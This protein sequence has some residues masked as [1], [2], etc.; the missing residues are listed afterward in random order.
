MVD[1]G[2]Y[3]PPRQMLEV[4]AE[5]EGNSRQAAQEKTDPLS[6]CAGSKEEDSSPAPRTIRGVNAPISPSSCATPCITANEGSKEESH[7]CR[8][9]PGEDQDVSSCD[10]HA[11][12]REEEEEESHCDGRDPHGSEPEHGDHHDDHHDSSKE[13][14]Q[15]QDAHDR[16]RASPG[17]EV[18]HP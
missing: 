5:D 1:K 11:S 13:I 9:S 7:H 15:T 10:G 12:S 16:G 8:Q 4:P 2:Q 6:S 3:Q 18:M 14:I 17:Q